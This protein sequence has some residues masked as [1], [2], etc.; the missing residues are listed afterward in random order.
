MA[1]VGSNSTDKAF[2]NHMLSLHVEDTLT[3]HTMKIVGRM[4]A[5]FHLRAEQNVNPNIAKNLTTRTSF[6]NRVQ[7]WGDKKS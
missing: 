5:G 4:R 6:T 3:N 2:A 1:Q 7:A